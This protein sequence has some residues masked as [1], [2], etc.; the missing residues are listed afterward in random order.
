MCRKEIERFEAEIEKNKKIIEEYKQICKN[1]QNKFEL[2]K[3]QASSQINQIAE[4]V[5]NCESCSKAISEI[6][7]DTNNC[8]ISEQSALSQ[9]GI[10]DS[11]KVANKDSSLQKVLDLE[12]ELIK[13][14]VALAESEDR[15]G[16]CT[17]N[18]LFVKTN[19]VRFN[20]SN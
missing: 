4:K 17:V 6:M 18:W 13:T 19:F 1:Y 5:K 12:N 14:K 2:E 20:G 10:T 7:N 11:S 16:V 8:E 9:H 15:N 3:E